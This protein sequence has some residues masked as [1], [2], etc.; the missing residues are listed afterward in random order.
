MFKHMFEKDESSAEIKLTPYQAFA[1]TVGCRVGT[2]N[3]AGV[4]TAIFFGGP[5]AV[6]WMWITAL[7][8]AAS[9]LI[10]SL[11]GS[12]YKD[13]YDNE[14]CGG[15]AYYMERG[16]KCRPLGILFALATLIGPVFMMSA[17]QTKTTVVA[18]SD[19]APKAPPAEVGL[20]VAAVDDSLF[21]YSMSAEALYIPSKAI[22]ISIASLFAQ[23]TKD[24]SIS[25]KVSIAMIR[26]VI[27]IMFSSKSFLGFTYI[28][29]KNRVWLHQNRN[30]FKKMQKNVLQA[31]NVLCFTVKNSV[32]CDCMPI[33][34]SQS[35]ANPDPRD[36]ARR[37][38]PR[39]LQYW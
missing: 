6:V 9:S 21:T 4:A 39:R 25:N 17:L 30:F 31:E 2:G 8:G 32:F 15:P 26:F 23:E 34:G 20:L 11:L 37:S 3:I 12:A 1:A 5:G 19:V 27:F 7:F 35:R 33:W 29:A 28:D 10:E 24:D 14:I 13:R 36:Q 18:L 22:P 38:K 16:L